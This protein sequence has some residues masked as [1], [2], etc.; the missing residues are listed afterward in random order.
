MSIFG[1]SEIGD[2]IMRIYLDRVTE[3]KAEVIQP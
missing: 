2:R 1:P 3:I